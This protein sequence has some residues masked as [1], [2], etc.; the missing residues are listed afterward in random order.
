MV[1]AKQTNRKVAAVAQKPTDGV[2]VVVVVY[3][4]TPSVWI[5]LMTDCTDAVLLCQ[6]LVITI[7]G[8][9]VAA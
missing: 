6:Q 5:G 7:R 2:R 1:V 3:C 9:P 8:Q 4:K